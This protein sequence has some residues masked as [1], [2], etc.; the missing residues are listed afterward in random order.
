[1]HAVAIA[2]DA[3]RLYAPN[4]SLPT[5]KNG[6][7]QFTRARP[8]QLAWLRYAYE[9]ALQAST[10]AVTALDAPSIALDKPS[11]VLAAAR[12]A[13]THQHIPSP[14]PAE[15]SGSSA[16]HDADTGLR[17]P[18]PVEQTL[19]RLGAVSRVLT[20]R[21]AAIDRAARSL[22]TEAAHASVSTLNDPAGTAP[23]VVQS[24]AAD[25]A[26]RFAADSFPSNP[27]AWL[28]GVQTGSYRPQPSSEEQPPQPHSS[29]DTDPQPA[30]RGSDAWRLFQWRQE[31][32]DHQSQPIHA[33]RVA[34]HDWPSPRGFAARRAGSRRLLHF[35]AAPHSW[36]G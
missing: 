24:P 13:V 8:A 32:I 29:P 10:K 15:R 26:A 23:T 28:A 22:L 18:G 9:T 1:M 11:S 5:S 4:R 25:D 6:R 14:A 19:R 36:L 33:A 35:G 20:L 31:R 17:R 12:E 16:G 2:A 7:Y 30:A 34:R 27:A 21:A 3:G